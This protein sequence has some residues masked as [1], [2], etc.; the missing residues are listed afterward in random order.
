LR[1][2]NIPPAPKPKVPLIAVGVMALVIAAVC[3]GLRLWWIEPLYPKIE[4]RGAAVLPFAG[5]FGLGVAVVLGLAWANRHRWRVVLHPNWGRVIGAVVL[6]GVTPVAVYGWVPSILGF[7][8]PLWFV[9]ILVSP[10][11]VLS[12]AVF[13]AVLLVIVLHLFWYAV[14]C[15]IVSGIKSRLVR[16]AVYTLMFWAAYSG[17]IMVAGTKVFML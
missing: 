12:F 9:T 6:A 13:L 4:P 8:T 16:V 5:L 11:K 14:S 3:M 7:F 10:F 15:L 2:D 1:G 17:V